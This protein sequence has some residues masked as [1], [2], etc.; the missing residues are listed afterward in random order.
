MSMA[1]RVASRVLV[2]G[3]GDIVFDGSVEEMQTRDDIRR[4]WLEVA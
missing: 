4:E 1:I 2:M 3:H